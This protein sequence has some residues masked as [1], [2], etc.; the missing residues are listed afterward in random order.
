MTRAITN[1][2]F[3]PRP[4]VGRVRE[5]ANVRA[6]MEESRLVTLVGPSGV[7]K[8]HLAMHLAIER[9][10]AS[11]QGGGVW[12]CDLALAKSAADVA[13]T[14]AAA[15]GAE[16][17]TDGVGAA[18]AM[19]GRILVVLDNFEHLVADARDTIGRWLAEAPS[20]RFL[21][22][23]RVPL[24]LAGEE[25]VAIAPLDLPDALEL[26]ERS[27]RS[28]SSSFD[29][30]ADREIA[31]AIVEMIDRLPL[32]IELAAR[33]TSVLSL[34]QLRERLAR[35]LD[36]L[37]G[38]RG[39]T[40]HASMRGAVLDSVDLLDPDER[41][42]FAAFTVF[43]NGF[44][45][46]SAEAVLGDV[47]VPRASMLD[48]L[49]ALVRSSLLSASVGRAGAARYSFFATIREVA[50]E[51]AA[52]EDF[53]TLRARF[54][55]HYAAR[56]SGAT[57]VELSAE[58][59][60]F[61]HAHEL[62]IALGPSHADEAFVIARA[63][64][65]VLSSRGLGRRAARLFEQALSAFGDAGD[66]A[67]RAQ[68]HLALGN[69]YRELGETPGARQSF[70]RGLDLATRSSSPG[71]AA[72]ALTR[73][74]EME[75]VAGDTGAARARYA[76]A[77]ELLAKTPEDRTRDEREAEAHMRLGHALRREGSLDAARR[78]CAR[79]SERYRHIGD[80]EG[81]AWTMYELAIVEMFAGD[82]VAAFARFDEGAEIARRG[83][84]RVVAG[85]LQTARGC[86]LQDLGRTDEALAHHAEAARVFQE[87]G[88][89]YREASALYYLATTYLERGETAEAIL[90]LR[91]ARERLAGV[92]AKRYDALIAGALASAHGATGDLEAAASSL[93]VAERAAEGVRNEPALAANV[94]IHRVAFELRTG[95]RKSL[96]DAV[97]DARALVLAHPTDDSRFALRL[98]SSGAQPAHA[99]LLV[100]VGGGAFRLPD[101]SAAV[102]LPARSPLRRVLDALAVSR[103]ERP[104]EVLTI[105]EII[106]AGWPGEK[107]GTDAALNRA[108]VALASLRKL[109]LRGALVQSGGGYSLSET[110]PTRR[111]NKVE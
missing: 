27:V 107:V 91:R 110:T 72:V 26:F 54:V 13:G 5:R 25:L 101:A 104:G 35:P 79:A 23:S 6:R 111:E 94:R 83:E 41:R 69:F 28:V 93:D 74:G 18:L 102:K 59:D 73:I 97:S 33:R 36:V 70:E 17:G 1:L 10:A 22:T 103:V 75:D 76:E 37:S 51:L 53:T 21:V 32:A 81:L 63:I 108:Y 9:V 31:T 42:A 85:A 8:T 56:A 44:T 96:D 39:S 61:L 29:A 47:V 65:P 67:S 105:D 89:R 84:V 45:L 19:R 2:T 40:R 38:A 95:A 20:A 71:L 68:I 50:E 82:D 100:E 92:G 16:V 48:T 80:D 106:A 88:S 43:R 55:A 60:D 7:G 14:V 52:R 30:T 12:S 64:A 3:E 62:A 98:L 90:V 24:D 15:I 77:L 49:D 78:A 66:E 87:A 86:L 34:E 57:R 58:L 109:G 46:E 4:L 99:A 11:R